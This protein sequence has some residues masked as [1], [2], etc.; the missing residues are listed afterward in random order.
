VL[1]CSA[2]TFSVR[3]HRARGRLASFLTLDDE[4]EEARHDGS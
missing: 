4:P 1:G 2:A 3:A